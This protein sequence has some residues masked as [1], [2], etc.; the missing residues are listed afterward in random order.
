MSQ[1]WRNRNIQDRMAQIRRDVD[2]A[3][4]DIAV[5]ARDLTRQLADWRY[6]VRRY[7]WVAAA[8]A[9]AVGY[10]IVPKR[11]P[12]IVQPDPETL[13]ALSREGRL[14][15][16]QQPTPFQTLA[17]VG[18]NQLSS[19]MLRSAASYLAD[20]FSAPSVSSRSG[21]STEK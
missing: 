7:P 18:L 1:D 16:G 4:D 11:T 20:K 2:Q 9:A 14:T 5:E 12:R 19:V 17:R 15:I 8:G 21:K 6:Y 13:T 10:L 3:V